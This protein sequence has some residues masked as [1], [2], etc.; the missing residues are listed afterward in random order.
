[1]NKNVDAFQGILLADK[2]NMLIK[3]A[4]GDWSETIGH[5]HTDKA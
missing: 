2:T 5:G 3:H 4:H 1:M